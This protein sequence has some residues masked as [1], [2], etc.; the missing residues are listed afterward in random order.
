MVGKGKKK[1]EDGDETEWDESRDQSRM[2]RDPNRLVT[3]NMLCASDQLNS[4]MISVSRLR[5][6]FDR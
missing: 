2:V 1:R 6:Y 3:L 4:W 5:S